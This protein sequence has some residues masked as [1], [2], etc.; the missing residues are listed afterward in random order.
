MPDDRRNVPVILGID[1]GTA[2][3]GYGVIEGG[4][5]PA[6][7]DAGVVETWPDQDMPGRL[8]T[9]YESVQELLEEFRPNRLAVEKLF[10]ARNVTTA[11]AVGQARGV[12]L[13][14]AAQANVPVA[15]YSPSEIKHAIA[16]YGKADKPQ[17]Q[18]MV[19]LILNLRSVPQPDDA[20]DAL[21]VAICDAQTT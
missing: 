15:E 11:I 2:R 7:L 9:L 1:P 8:V 12:V 5:K 20:A 16:G 10:F 13:L 19:R 21:A 18:E 4:I 17:M 3:L 14:A 6:L